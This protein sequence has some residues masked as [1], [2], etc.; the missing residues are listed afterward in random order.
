MTRCANFETLFD[1]L[2]FMTLVLVPSLRHLLPVR[3]NPSLSIS[4]PFSRQ[5]HRRTLY[6]PAHRLARIAS[7]TTHS[8]VRKSH[9][10][11]IQPLRSHNLTARYKL[12][13]ASLKGTDPEKVLQDEVLSNAGGSATRSGDITN[14]TPTFHDVAIPRKPDPP[15]S[16]GTNFSPLVP[17]RGTHADA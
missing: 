12:L 4:S 10:G 11:G 8:R 7:F 9:S 2:F 13:E 16:D 3:P 5:C 1:C 14:T 6:R 15:A 17:L